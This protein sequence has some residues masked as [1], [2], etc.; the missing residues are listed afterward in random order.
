LLALLV[1]AVVGLLS[2]GSASDA[3]PNLGA[4]HTND[5]PNG[6]LGAGADILFVSGSWVYDPWHTG[7]NEIHPVKVCTRVGRWDG[8]WDTPPDII[9]RVRAQLDIAAT[10]ATKAAQ[11]RPEN[12][13]VV[14]PALDSC[15]AVIIT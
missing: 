6:G 2:G 11:Q 1:G 13:W 5:D 4:V 7:W 14:H 10:D 12:Q 8:D 9:L 3:N 15:S